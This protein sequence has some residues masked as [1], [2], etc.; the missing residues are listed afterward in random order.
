MRVLRPRPPGGRL[1]HAAALALLLSLRGASPVS[2]DAP[3]T[4]A[5]WDMESFVRI[6]SPMRHSTTGRMP[7]MVWNLPLPLDDELVPM[8][9][10]GRL[11]R[12]IAQ[13]A[14]RGI[15]PTVN[16]GWR[17]S[18]TGALTM[19]RALQEGG[20]PVNILFPDPRLL[21]AHIYKDST[22][23][24]VAPT[25]LSAGVVRRWPCFPEADARE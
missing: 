22:T 23:G 5:A 16:L 6:V 4:D 13:L 19:A 15:V 25:A 20:R 7:F 21:E 12:Y 9:R 8:H 1:A 24:I 14:E 18:M 3:A 2:A 17:W 11:G 10:D